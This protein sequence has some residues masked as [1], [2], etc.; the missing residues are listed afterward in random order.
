MEAP[1]AEQ[2]KWAEW[3]QGDGDKEY[4]VGRK[5]RE[6]KKCPVGMPR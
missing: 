4:R 2:P 5:M 3:I 1:I 6:W